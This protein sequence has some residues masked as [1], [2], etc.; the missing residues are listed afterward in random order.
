MNERDKPGLSIDCRGVV[1]LVTEYLEGGLPPDLTAEVEAHL[2]LCEGCQVYLEQMRR[3]IDELGRVP[4]ETLPPDAQEELLAAFRTFRA[5][6]TPPVD[7][8][9]TPGAHPQDA[10]APKKGHGTPDARRRGPMRHIPEKKQGIGPPAG[11]VPLLLAVVAV[12]V[13]AAIV[14]GIAAS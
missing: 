1:E 4:V 8:R 14:I 7:A 11:I 9:V 3:T 13:V 5:G 10:P 6:E 2:A 12:L